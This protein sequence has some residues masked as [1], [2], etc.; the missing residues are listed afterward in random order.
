MPGLEN[1]ALCVLPV[2][3]VAQ[4]SSNVTCSCGPNTNCKYVE[5]SKACE[6]LQGFVGDASARSGCAEITP[7]V[8]LV[9]RGNLQIPLLFQ[10]VLQQQYNYSYE[11]SQTVSQVQSLT[12][13]ILQLVTGYI[14]Y[15]ANVTD[16]QSCGL[17][18]F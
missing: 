13:R 3:Q 12:D 4:S 9:L 8:V 1:Q 7:S 15:S 11:Y 6:C 14:L 16:F 17:I 18:D 5:G 10:A 2:A